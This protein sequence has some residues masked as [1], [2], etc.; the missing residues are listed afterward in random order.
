MPSITIRGD[1]I[2]L[3]QLLKWAAVVQS[4]GEAKALIQDGRVKV[5]EQTETRRGRQLHPGDSV[6]IDDAVS[7]QVLSDVD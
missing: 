6:T 2:R 1:S 3:D 7:L 5:N 4:G